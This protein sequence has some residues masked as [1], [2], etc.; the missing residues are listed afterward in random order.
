L[1][2]VP[3][4]IALI[5]VNVAHHHD[6]GRVA[7]DATQP[8]DLAAVPQILRGE[9]VAEFVRM[10][11]ETDSAAG[12]LK[13]VATSTGRPSRSSRRFVLALSGRIRLT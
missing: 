10:D 12:A 1:I 6:I 9:R 13:K 7:E 3:I 11:T 5:Q 2:K 8:L 4:Q